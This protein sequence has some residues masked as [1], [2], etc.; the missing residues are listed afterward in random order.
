MAHNNNDMLKNLFIVFLFIVITL[1]TAFHEGYLPLISMPFW[2]SIVGGF[3]ISLWLALGVSTKRLL[4]LILGI[5]IIEYIKETI[6]IRSGMWEYHGTNGFYNFGVWA[7]VIGGLAAYTLATKI[8]IPRMQ[9]VKLSIPSWVNPLLVTAIFLLVLLT[10]GNYRDGAG[11]LF[12]SFYIA[13]YI[14]CFYLSLK[15]DFPV[16]AGIVIASWIL[17]TPSEYLGSAAS[18]I[19]TFTHNPDFPPFFLVAGCWPLEILAQYSL[20]AFLADEPLNPTGG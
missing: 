6:G 5:F 10:L 3:S 18:N 13:L 17:G 12:W 16:F 19:W 20:S 4:S 2:V 7:W 11:I 15:I 8:V 14:S 1:F 9:R